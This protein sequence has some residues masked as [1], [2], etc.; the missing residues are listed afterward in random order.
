MSL[1]YAILGFLGSTPATGY[2]IGREFAQG[3][4]AFWSALPSQIYPELRALEQ[5]GWI[6]GTHDASDRLNRRVFA[7]TAQGVA[8]LQQWVEAPMEYPP[9]R[10]AERVRLIFLDR[11]TPDVVRRHLLSH[12]AHFRDKLATWRVI[13]A[14]MTDGTHRQMRARLAQR[15]AGEHD[16]ILLTKLLAYDGNIARAE[17]EIAWA[18]DALARL[19]ALWS[20]AEE[21]AEPI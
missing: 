5:L 10:D 15:P 18:E 9:E 2:V 11:S 20:V 8:A 16:L 1:R 4:G 19:E 13:R 17:L 7:L 21:V 12:A 6:E 3:A 14:A